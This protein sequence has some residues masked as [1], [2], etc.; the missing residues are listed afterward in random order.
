MVGRIGSRAKNVQNGVVLVGEN[1][2][3]SV[4]ELDDDVTA[5]IFASELH[6][7]NAINSNLGNVGQSL[8]VDMFPEFLNSSCHECP[9]MELNL[10]IEN[11][12][13][14]TALGL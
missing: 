2:V 6:V 12:E 9:K 7:D 8:L 1:H 10:T 11:P 5:P 4:V 14:I 13:G 3:S